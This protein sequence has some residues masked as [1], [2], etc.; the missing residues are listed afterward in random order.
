M[1]TLILSCNTGE[2]HNSCAKAIKEY[3]EKQGEACEVKDGLEFIS[4]PFAKFMSWGH[5]YVYRHMPWLFKTGYFYTEKHPAVFHEDSKVYRYMTRGTECIYRY[6]TEGGF[7]AVICTHVFTALMVTDMLKKYPMN[8]VTCYVATDYTCSPS[9]K[10]SCLDFYFI[11][12]RSLAHEFE[13]E[14]IPKEKIIASGIPVRQMFYLWHGKTE[15]KIRTGISPS[16]NH[17]L[18]M[19]GSM[20]CGPME[21]LLRKLVTYQKAEWEITVVCGRNE[22]LKVRLDKCFGQCESVHIR[23]YVKDMSLLMDSADLYVTKPGG[24]SVSE[25]AV[26]ELPMV[27]IDAVAGCE[28][29][30]RVYFVHRGG[31]ETGNNIEELTETCIKFM[32]NSEKR[33]I[34]RENLSAMGGYHA[35]QCIYEKMKEGT[36]HIYGLHS[37]ENDKA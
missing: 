5:S 34:M 25:A 8:I 31:A 11:P 16:R 27:L 3:Y 12:D 28:E 4:V 19:C 26:K 9:T 14:N 18:L 21:K 10:D 2:G 32:D 15:A 36:E 30:N 37:A 24:I 22:K 7:D 20:G 29:Y 13:C 33:M 6:I 1:R 17:L 23:G 35:S